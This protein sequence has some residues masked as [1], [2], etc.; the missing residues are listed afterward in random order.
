[1]DRRSF[2]K[3]SGVSAAAFCMQGCAAT[4][5]SKLS[6]A[7]GS[8]P[9]I[10]YI[11]ADDLGY[12]ELGCYGQEK[13]KT[14]NIDRIAKQGVK[15]TQHYSGSP[16]CAPTRST[17]LEGKHTGHSF[18]RSNYE[19]GGWER[20]N[21]EGQLPLPADTV[22]LPKLLKKAGY[23]TGAMG[24]WGL[25]GPDTSGEPHKQGFDY[26]YGYLC[27]RQA[28]NYYPTHLWKDSAAGLE[29]V[30]LDNE[31]FSAHQRFPK[32]KNPNDPENY[33]QYSGNDYAPDLMTEEALK[34]VKRNKDNPFFLYLPYTIPHVALQVPEDSLE[35][36]E[37]MEDDPYLGD[38][39]YLPNRTPHATYAAMITRMDDY[40]GKVMDLLE[41]LGLEENTLIMFSSDNG[42]TFNGGCDADFFDSVEPLRGL[43]CSVYEGGI[44]VPLVAKWPGRIPAGTTTD[45]ISAIWDVLPTCTAAAGA[46]TPDDISGIS[47]LPTMLSKDEKQKKH[48]YLYWE[49]NRQIAVRMGKWKAVRRRTDKTVDTPIKLYNLEKDIDESDNVADKHPEV[50]AKIK[51]IMKEAHTPSEY[52]PFPGEP[53]KKWTE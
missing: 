37:G 23:T 34:F 9:N 31:Y 30:E 50:V 35:Q 32:D 36:Y 6:K 24:K 20:G 48:E 3:L 43:K 11:M 41:K 51:K 13:I 17:L 5:M 2:I 38:Q 53:R 7:R 27:Q 28:H 33:E 15:F 25:G 14:P 45:H 19:L 1:M 21:R 29:K 12:S 39:A 26:F 46:P 10:V 16:V 4:S 52:F 8:K 42:T 49:Y 40:V 22:T 18:V 44:R 47:M